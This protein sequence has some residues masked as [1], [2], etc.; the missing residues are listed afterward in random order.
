[1]SEHSV[2]PMGLLARVTRIER[3]QSFL[4]PLAGLA[5]VLTMAALVAFATEGPGLV[6]AQRVEL[7]NQKG[8][9]QATLA[10]DTAGVILTLFDRSGR[11]T[12]SLRLSKDQRLTVL[13]GAG[14]EVA[15]LGA[16]RVR[17]LVE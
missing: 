12:A 13:D 14:R 3:L 7:V 9:A 11:A 1:M 4:R 16:P 8:E 5:M 15:G 6:Q 17:H 2:D 10:A